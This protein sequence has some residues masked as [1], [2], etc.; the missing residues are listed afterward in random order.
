LVVIDPGHGGRDPGTISRT[1]VREKDIVLS[2]GRRLAAVLR[3]R[4]YDARMT[5]TSDT[6]IALGDR[7]HIA[8]QMKG[9]RQAALFMSIHANAHP[10]SAAEGF[11]TYFLSEAR[12]AD[13]RRVAELENAAAA[14]ER[15]SDGPDADAI[16]V[17]LRGLRNDF[18]QHASNDLGEAV[19]R[20]LASAH[21]GS[22]RGVK[23]APF[24]VL[25]GAAMPAVLVETAFLSN[26]AEARLLAS[27]AFQDRLARALADGVER[28]FDSHEHLWA[29]EPA[30]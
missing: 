13:E 11:E 26:R 23:Q 16:D 12:T 22:N 20:A 15:E 3:D 24:R 7:P 30:R 1:G 14:Y 2:I 19:Q 21:P 4:G 29:A 17:I 10:S 8:N 18:Y 25:V 5:R 9:S 27:D 28:F 6:L